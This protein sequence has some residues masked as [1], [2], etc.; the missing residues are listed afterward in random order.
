MS[1]P[2]RIAVLAFSLASFSLS[3]QEKA[4]YAFGQLLATVK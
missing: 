1:N 4:H 3:A 2:L